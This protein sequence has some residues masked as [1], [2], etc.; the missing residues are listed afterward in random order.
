MFSTPYSHEPKI[1][2]NTHL[3]FCVC[4]SFVNFLSA[5]EYTHMHNINIYEDTENIYI[6]LM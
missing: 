5:Q 1:I 4:V 2:T 3:C 6:C